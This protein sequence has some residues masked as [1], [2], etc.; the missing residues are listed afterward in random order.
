[1]AADTLFASRISNLN[2]G[3]L[4]PLILGVP[5]IIFGLTRKSPF[6]QKCVPLI[7]TR[8]AAVCYSLLVALL[9]AMSIY[10]IYIKAA[11]V[12]PNVDAV[13]VLG[14]AVHNDVPSVTLT[15]RVERAAQYAADNPNALIVV[16]GGQGPQENR[17][18]ASV[19][20]EMLVALGIGEERIII[21]DT[22]GSTLENFAFSKTLL[23]DRLGDSISVAVVTDAYHTFRARLIAQKVGFTDVTCLPSKSV[24]CLIPNFYL[25]ELASIAKA[26][27]TGNI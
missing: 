17:S 11:P 6:W 27:V 10:C 5:L 23:N 20:R 22:A 2:F 12:K 1:M 25:R 26:L 24:E 13:I 18:E 15:Y 19:M 3:V 21:E 4:A 8:I 7:I 14:A 16:S 9:A